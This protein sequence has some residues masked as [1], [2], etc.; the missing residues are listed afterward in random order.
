[1]IICIRLAWLRARFLRGRGSNAAA[2]D[3]ETTYLL[4]HAAWAG[5]GFVDALF[6]S[7]SGL[8]TTGAVERTLR[9]RLI[10]WN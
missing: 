9:R 6:E 5:M 4:V 7:M 2:G 3:W 8:T 1:M 10:P